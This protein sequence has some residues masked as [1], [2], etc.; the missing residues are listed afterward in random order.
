MRIDKNRFLQPFESSWSDMD[1]EITDY[2]VLGAA[3][4]DHL[5]RSLDD[6]TVAEYF[7]GS[8]S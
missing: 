1:V 2:L 6:V 5:V 3:Y 8:L 4:M 7:K